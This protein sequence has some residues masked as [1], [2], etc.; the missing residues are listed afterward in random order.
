MNYCGPWQETGSR[1]YVRGGSARGQHNHRTFQRLLQISRQAYRCR[2]ESSVAAFSE[3][4]GSASIDIE[5]LDCSLAEIR[6]A[7]S[8]K[9]QGFKRDD[10]RTD[11][12]DRVK[13][14]A[15]EIHC[16]CG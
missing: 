16:E 8:N 14:R 3:L 6:A 7:D 13:R 11:D 5:D 2:F 1:R 15:E 4:T 9:A 10:A 12:A